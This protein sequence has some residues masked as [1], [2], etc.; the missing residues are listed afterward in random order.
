ME[1]ALC[2][3]QHLPTLKDVAVGCR[4]VCMIS[5]HSFRFPTTTTSVSVLNVGLLLLL[6][7]E[8]FATLNLS[9]SVCGPQQVVKADF[10]QWETEQSLIS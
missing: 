4:S 8:T 5:M 7:V 3:S 1:T 9:D 6:W 2:S 10:Q